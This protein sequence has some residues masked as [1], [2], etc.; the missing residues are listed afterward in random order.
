ML[1]NRNTPDRD[2]KLYPAMCIFGHPI[3]DFIPIPPG[4][5]RPHRTWRDTLEA[6]ESALRNRHIVGNYVRIQNQIGPSPLKWD[7]T[8]RVI[9]VRQFDQYVVKVDGSGRVTLRNRKFLRKYSPVILPPTTRTITMDIPLP[10]MPTQ[11]STPS[12]T[13]LPP[14]S[15]GSSGNATSP[16]IHTNPFIR[17][18]TNHTRTP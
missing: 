3:R 7:K 12:L 8:G 15:H 14:A 11:S 16:P 13:T 9:E 17:T 2:T 5:Y 6:R 4:N 10:I 1:Q 18:A